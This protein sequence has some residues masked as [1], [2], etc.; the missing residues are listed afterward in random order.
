MLD[1]RSPRPVRTGILR[2]AYHPTGRPDVPSASGPG[3][4]DSVS[5]HPHFAR[6]FPS[7]TGRGSHARRRRRHAA[8]LRQDVLET[9]RRHP[10]PVP[11][12]RSG[13]GHRHGPR[14]TRRIVPH[15]RPTLPT[16]RRHP[17]RPGREHLP[18]G[19]RDPQRRPRTGRGP[20]IPPRANQQIVPVG[21]HPHPRPGPLHPGGDWRHRTPRGGGKPVH[22]RHLRRSRPGQHQQHRHRRRRRRRHQRTDQPQRQ[23][24]ALVRPQRL[25]PTG[26][27]GRP[28]KRT[29]DLSRNLR[30]NPQRPNFRM[31]VEQG[32]NPCF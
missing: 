29:R 31:R 3:S 24:L 15:L 32:N 13:P 27:V 18:H 25:R 7:G 26:A 20:R 28:Q 1:S 6:P 14:S 16:L 8:P 23:K 12:R 10:R 9:L 30:R 21:R 11:R 4:L 2:R 22:R 17:Q 5:S 19:R